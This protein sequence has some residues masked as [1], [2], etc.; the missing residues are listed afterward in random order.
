M[1]NSGS[2]IYDGGKVIAE[3]HQARANEVAGLQT[4]Q[5]QLE[6]LSFNVSQAY[7]NELLAQ[8][9]RA[10]R[11]AAGHAESGQRSTREAQVK[12]GVAPRVDLVTAHVPTVQA[13]V[14]LIQAQGTQASARGAFANQLGLDANTLVMPVNNTPS[15]PAAT[16]ITVL[17]YDKAI[18]RALALRPDYLSAQ[19]AVLAAQ[20]NVQAQRA[21]Y[22]P[23]LTGSASYGTNSTTVNGTNFT[24]SSSSG[25]TLSIPLYD[26]GITRAQVEQA[27]AQLDLANAQ[28]AQ[29]KL[30]V[31]LNV[32][33]GV[34]GVISDQAAVTQTV[35]AT[36]SAQESLRAT[37]AQYKA[38]VTNL[39]SLLQAQTNLTSA[40]TNE[41]TAIFNLRIA[42]QTYVFALGESSINPTAVDGT[43]RLPLGAGAPAKGASA[44][45]LPNSRRMH[46]RFAAALAAVFLLVA[47]TKQG[48]VAT[49]GAGNSWTRP[50]ILRFAENAEPA[51]LNVV[52]NSSAVTGDLSMFIY[53]YAVRYNEKAQPV[54]DAL[55][56]IPTV[57]NGDVSKDG[58]TLK[59]KLRRNIKWQDG[60]PL[61]CADLKFTWKAVM[62]PHNN[63]VTTDGYKDIRD[64]DC[65][66]PYVALIHMKRLYAPYLQQLWGVNGNAAILPEHLLAK[67]NDDRGSFN[68]APYNSM[69]IGSGPFKV[70]EWQ[71]GNEV[72]MQA[73]PDFY[74]GQTETERSHLQDHAG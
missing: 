30:G 21:G 3:I 14:A 68:N 45:F 43:D 55:V 28:L 71:R 24:T 34:V 62:N 52:L 27:Q 70:I 37:Q 42:E 63:V 41:L 2:S 66:D 8:A 7:Y 4:Y 36:S 38:G 50:G 19:N 29:T 17:P 61:T 48:T 18:T 23:T 54:P 15:N 13:Q 64:I 58:L 74:L 5:R 25:F 40:E 72:R 51:S 31:Q 47:C 6:T 44:R 67:Y 32:Q 20:Y 11:S 56:E 16:L 49:G 12:T 59:Y 53:S 65:S 35:V 73:N 39:F 46:K 69:P 10:R 26:Q 22:Y 57:A 9:T 1:R 33:Q 60:K